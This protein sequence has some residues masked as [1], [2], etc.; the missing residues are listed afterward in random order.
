[1]REIRKIDV[2]NLERNVV[3]QEL[4]LNIQEREASLLDELSTASDIDEIRILQGRL[5]EIDDYLKFPVRLLEE[6]EASRVEREQ[7]KYINK[8]QARRKQ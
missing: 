4:Q 3:W 6:S 7:D 5:A 8:K 2:G 1:M